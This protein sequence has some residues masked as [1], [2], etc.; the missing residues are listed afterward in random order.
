MRALQILSVLLAVGLMVGE[1][2]RSWGVGRPFVHV[3]DDF[4]AAG[5]LLLAAWLTGR[6]DHRARRIVVAIWAVIA[7]SALPSLVVKIVAPASMTPGNLP[8]QLLTGLVGLALLV[9]IGG[10]VAAVL[11]PVPEDRS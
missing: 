11:L 6:P 3:A 9:S 8:P 5:L 7:A 4:L 10:L 1:S 2:I